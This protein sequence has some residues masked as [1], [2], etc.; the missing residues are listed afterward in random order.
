M[1]L[2][3]HNLSGEK[4]RKKKR[5]GRGLGS[6]LGTYS[7]RGIKGQKARTGGKKGLKIHGLKQT[8]MKLKKTRG[9]TSLQKK[10]PTVNVGLLNEKFKE[11]E[12][13]TA[14]K[15]VERGII[16]TATY[17]IKILGKGTLSKKLTVQA[18]AFSASAKALIEKIGGQAEIIKKQ[19]SGKEEKAKT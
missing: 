11:G 8:I 2:T 16:S 3:L 4:K 17:G 1:L 14:S 15:L 10:R 19:I 13:V 12:M 18:D 6:G 9:F 5:V 7:G